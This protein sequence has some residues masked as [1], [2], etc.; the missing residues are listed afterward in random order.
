MSKKVV[1]LHLSICIIFFFVALCISS[2]EIVK[3]NDRRTNRSEIINTGGAQELTK[4]Q[5]SKKDLETELPYPPPAFEPIVDSPP[6]LPP[7]PYPP[8]APEPPIDDFN[9]NT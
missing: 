5:D 7:Y 4:T 6:P 9:V 8:P 1:S 3:K 2:S